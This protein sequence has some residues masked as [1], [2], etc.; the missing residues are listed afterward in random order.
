MNKINYKQVFIIA[1][2][3]FKNS[4]KSF[5]YFTSLLFPIILFCSFDKYINNDF[6]NKTINITKYVSQIFAISI[7]IIIFAISILYISALANLI[8]RDKSSKMSEMFLSF[9][10]AK[11]QLLGKIMGIYFLIVIQFIVFTLFVIVYTFY[12]NTPVVI[13][14]INN[15][16]LSNLAYSIINIFVSFLLLFTWTAEFASYITDSSQTIVA[17]IPTMLF[18][19]M[20]CIQGVFFSV[21]SNWFEAFSIYGI[22]FFLAASF[23]PVGTFVV[24]SL[25]LNNVMPIWEA[26]I[27][28]LI[29][30]IIS[31]ILFN[32]A[33]K[34]YKYG[35]LNHQKSNII[36]KA[37]N[38]EFKK[39][40]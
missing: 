40:G 36:L 31:S 20:A 27:I 24:P 19:A 22:I 29:Q 38:D 15:I 32:S 6:K 12:T 34:R 26:Y 35:L 30:L 18:A 11:E 3:E 39:K 13:D 10:G 1:M 5:S 7:P 14:F 9:V 4:C 33:A 37:M 17:T 8:A 21:N 16:S 25:I 23:P 2:Y 28:L